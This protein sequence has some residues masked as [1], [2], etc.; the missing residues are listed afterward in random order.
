MEGSNTTY[1]VE[2]PASRFRVE[3]K[4]IPREAQDPEEAHEVALQQLESQQLPVHDN[5]TLLR[6]GVWNEDTAPASL[7]RSWYTR[8][9]KPSQFPR[10]AIQRCMLLLRPRR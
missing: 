8:K 6:E 2:P 9:P 1:E 5:Q 3:H 4:S 7:W 10:L